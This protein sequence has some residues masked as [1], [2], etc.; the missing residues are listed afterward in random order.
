MDDMHHHHGHSANLLSR[1][2][3]KDHIIE[4][5]KF[6]G[7]NITGNLDKET[8][9]MMNMPR[10]G[11]KDR[12]GKNMNEEEH[13]R[14]KRYALQGKNYGIAASVANYYHF[15]REIRF[16]TKKTFERQSKLIPIDLSRTD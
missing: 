14:S 12:I 7:L 4:F 8:V 2:G 13:H 11:V 16:F 1:D 15:L 9:K 10:C 6:A 3:L 5:Q